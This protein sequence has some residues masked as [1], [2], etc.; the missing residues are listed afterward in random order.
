[1]CIAQIS[2]VIHVEQA[3]PADLELIIV[4]KKLKVVQVLEKKF[5]LDLKFVKYIASGSSYD[6]IHNY[7]PFN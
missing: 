2:Q 7:F 5:L 6:L 1:M 3:E 4:T